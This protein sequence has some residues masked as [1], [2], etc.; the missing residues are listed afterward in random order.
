MKDNLKH[1]AGYQKEAL[2]YIIE[3]IEKGVVKNRFDLA[4][5]MNVSRQ[6][7]SK[8]FVDGYVSKKGVETLIA[9]YS[10]AREYIYKTIPKIN[11]RPLNVIPK[12][13]PGKEI[14]ILDTDV[15]ASIKSSLSGLP[16]LSPETFIS[17]PIF[18]EGE[19]A[20]QVTGNSMKG[21]IN[22]GDWVIIKK[23]TM[24]TSIIYGESYMVTT[25]VDNIKTVKFLKPDDHDEDSIMLVP[26]N[27][28]QF[29]PQSI[30]KDD[31]LEIFRVIGLF[32]SI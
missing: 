5:K 9:L 4:K 15:Y 1:I 18:S 29:E 14:P 11:D 27:I 25:K 23:L 20:V 8:Y 12:T 22:H 26:Y 13:I 6:A 32:R 17:I 31:I 7:V 19:C 2:K 30:P 24:R 16:T 10:D 3:L 21:Y 28:E